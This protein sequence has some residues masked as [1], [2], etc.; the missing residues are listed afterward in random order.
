VDTA[1]DL[2]FV[3]EVYRRLPALSAQRGRKPSRSSVGTK[4]R[5]APTDASPRSE[6]ERAGSPGRNDDAIGWKDVLDLLAREPALA[7]MNRSV[8]QKALHEG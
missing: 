4:R 7:E 6:A 2:G 1:E 8:Q 5:C 3:R